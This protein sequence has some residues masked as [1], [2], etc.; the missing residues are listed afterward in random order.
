MA[1]ERARVR[2]VQKPWGAVDLRPWSEVRPDGV[3]VGELWYER[4]KD[5][6]PVSA[7]QLK[8]LVATEPLSIQVHPDDAFARTKGLPAGKTEA[9]YVLSATPDAKVA[10]GLTHRI[11]SQQLRQAIDDGSIANLVQW[12]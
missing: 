6:A 5:T 7:L 2:A 3:P 10:L 4:D 11:T 8:V 12:R 9:W 1:I